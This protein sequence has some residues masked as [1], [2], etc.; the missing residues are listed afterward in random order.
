[1]P[2]SHPLC[3]NVAVPDTFVTGLA[4]I[5]RVGGGNLRF[6]FSVTQR[7]TIFEDAR[8]ERVIVARIVI[9]AR[10]A[11]VAAKAAI[12]AAFGIGGIVEDIPIDR[13]H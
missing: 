1:M 12:V 2:N 7:S 8:K 10:A 6:T 11:L 13:D 5:E 9:S 4:R 3:E